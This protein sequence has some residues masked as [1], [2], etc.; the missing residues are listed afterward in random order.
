MKRADGSVMKKKI[1]DLIEEALNVP[2][3]T[4]TEDT[5]IA[6]ILRAD[7]HRQEPPVPGTVKG[8]EV[9]PV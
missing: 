4:I 6:R 9:Q 7:H 1:I 8:Q 2:K 5:R 3:G